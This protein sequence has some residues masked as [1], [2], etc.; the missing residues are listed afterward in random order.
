MTYRTLVRA[1][2]ALTALGAL[3]ALGTPARAEPGDPWVRAWGLSNTGQL[4]NGTTLDQQTPSSVRGLRRD[5]VRELAGNGGSA[6]NRAFAVA[7]LEDG[8]VESWGGNGNGQLGDGTTTD[9]PVPVT[10]AGLS[11]VSTVAAGNGFAAAVRGGRVW[12]W[13]QNNLGQLGNGV[14]TDAA[15]SRPVLSQSLRGVTD[16][17]LGCGYTLA[18]RD[19]GTVWS[20]GENTYGQLGLGTLAHQNTPKR[21][22]GLTDVVAVSAGCHHSVALR[23]D[24]TVTSWG[25]NVNG[26]LGNDSVVQSSSPVDVKFLDGVTAVY[27]GWYHSFAVLADGSLRAWGWNGSGQLGDGT[28][29][30]RTTPVPVPGLTGVQAL[31]PGYQYSVALLDDQ[32]VV[33][34]GD[35][36]SGQLGDGTTTASPTP[37]TALP[38]GSGTTRVPASIPWR[39]S[40]AY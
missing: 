40:Y 8:T 22:P 25:Y 24:G 11:G 39:T 4:G 18:L 31:S 16:I 2:V 26:Q 21:V 23:A 15:T 14:T 34:W 33:A 1:G 28:T 17:A 37:V 19:D 3:I 12:A 7:L 30:Q 10:V 36:S 29:V 35:N 38:P 20:W 9:R 13:G 32:S 27:A 6:A 5:D